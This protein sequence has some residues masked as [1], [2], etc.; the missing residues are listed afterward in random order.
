M[1]I[2]LVVAGVVYRGLTPG[3]PYGNTQ[4]RSLEM[5]SIDSLGNQDKVSSA[6]FNNFI[7]WFKQ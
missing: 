2:A 5:N 3:I 4:S 1:V 7:A 6:R